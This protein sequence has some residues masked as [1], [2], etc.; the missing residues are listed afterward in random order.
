MA[1]VGSKLVLLL[2]LILL[3]T[4]QAA[5]RLEQTGPQ[6]DQPGFGPAVATSASTTPSA[7]EAAAVTPPGLTIRE[8]NRD[9]LA[10]TGEGCPGNR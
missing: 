2:A 9:E 6:V 1:H 3:G 4:A 8:G 7:I 10:A 5:R